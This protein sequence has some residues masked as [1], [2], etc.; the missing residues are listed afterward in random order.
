MNKKRRKEPWRTFFSIIL[1]IASILLILDNFQI[2]PFPGSGRVEHNLSTPVP[3]DGVL[4]HGVPANGGWHP[5]DAFDF[6]QG[7]YIF[8]ITH[9]AY[10]RVINREEVSTLSVLRNHPYGLFFWIA[11]DENDGV[12]I[13]NSWS[14]DSIFEYEISISNYNNWERQAII[15]NQRLPIGRESTLL[16]YQFG[17]IIDLTRIIIN[18]NKE[19]LADFNQTSHTI[20]ISV[21]RID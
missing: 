7:D 21:T 15:S 1:S 19:Y 4:T 3:A 8:K 5:F 6:W 11:I 18:L 9:L 12:S 2:F 14:Y 16:I 10:G 20:I 13:F 17:E